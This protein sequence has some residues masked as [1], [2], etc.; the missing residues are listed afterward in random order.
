ML[1]S[2]QAQDVYGDPSERPDLGKA[3]RYHQEIERSIRAEGDGFVGFRT[4]VEAFSS[5]AA[6]NN[7]LALIYGDGENDGTWRKVGAPNT[8]TWVKFAPG[9]WEIAA[10]QAQPSGTANAIVATSSVPVINGLSVQLCILRPIATNTGPVT[11]RVGSAAAYP[12]LD[13]HG[14]QLGAGFLMPGG[15]HLVA[16]DGVA[17]RAFQE[18]D[19]FAAAAA[20]EADR[21]R[22][23]NAANAAASSVGGPVSVIENFGAIS[24]FTMPASLNFLRTC[25]HTSFDQGGGGLYRRAPSEPS[26]DGKARTSNGVW[27]ELAERIIEPQHFGAR[28]NTAFDC[29]TALAAWQGM[30]RPSGRM[31]NGLYRSSTP[32]TLTGFADLD[33]HNPTF[34]PTFDEGYAVVRAFANPGSIV[35]NQDHRGTLRVLWPTRDWTKDRTSFL[36]QNAYNCRGGYA[37]LNATRDI[38]VLGNNSGVPTANIRGNVHN[39]FELSDMFG[40]QQGVVVESQTSDGWSNAHIFNGG[41]FYGSATS[42]QMA[43]GIHAAKPGHF[44]VIGSPYQN[45]GIRIMHPSLEWAGPGKYLGWIEGLG[46]HFEPRYME[47]DV[48]DVWVR[49][50]GAN[51]DIILRTPSTGYFDPSATAADQRIDLTG[52][53]GIRLICANELID[54]DADLTFFRINNGARPTGSFQNKGNGHALTLRTNDPTKGIEIRNTAGAL[55][56]EITRTGLWRVNGGANRFGHATS[57]P[58]TGAPGDFLINSNPTAIGPAGSRYWVVAWF[59][60]AAHVGD[61]VTTP[62]Q[63]VEITKPTGT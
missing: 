23:E 46:V 12:V 4:L 60:V 41:F 20:T 39:I 51:H 5:L 8:G 48:G 61:P 49:V 21:I 25:W 18:Y 34:S 54:A 59:C 57:A 11:M 22:A 31:P 42:A 47:A 29:T 32:L 26:H 28:V 56:V 45:N 1:L 52:A 27:L 53:T 37:S 14:Q 7:T 13:R 24:A 10:L 16:F 50:L 15:A 19:Y 35:E 30:G 2:L 44:V 55:A 63:Y 58:G 6:P 33:I 36:V 43:A 3:L 62:A 40:S 38:H 17:W 9:P